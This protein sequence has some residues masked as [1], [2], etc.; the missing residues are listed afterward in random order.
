MIRLFSPS[1]GRARGPSHFF[2]ST[3]GQD[4]FDA[5]FRCGL[6]FSNWPFGV[7]GCP[8]HALTSEQG[9]LIC[10]PLYKAVWS[11]GSSVEARPRGIYYDL[12]Y[13]QIAVT[14]RRVLNDREKSLYT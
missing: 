13:V 5:R 8:A 6:F 12:L 14:R 2:W 3:V 11:G 7:R 1:V 10:I 9:T 4:I